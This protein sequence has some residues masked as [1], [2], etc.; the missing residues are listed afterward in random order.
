MDDIDEGTYENPDN[1]WD[2][3]DWHT[4]DEEIDHMLDEADWNDLLDQLGFDDD[5]DNS[6]F[7]S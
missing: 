5:D 7:W 2:D 3:N 4:P 1:D 6:D